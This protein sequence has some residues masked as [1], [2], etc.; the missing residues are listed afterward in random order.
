MQQNF[1]DVIFLS[2]SA[3]DTE[4]LNRLEPMSPFSDDIVDFLHELSQTLSKD[5][6][7]RNF[8]DVAT[9]AFFCRKGNIQ[10]I[11]KQYSSENILR[12]GR[13]V[14]FHIAPSNVPVNFAY[15]LVC[16]ILAG[17]I[18]IVR[19]PSKE[20]EQV[21]IISNAIT[22]L[23][24]SGKHKIITDRI[25]LIRYDRKSAATSLLSAIC[26]VRIIWGGDETIHEIRK[27]S[28]APRSFDI[29]FADRYS[30]CVI[31][32]DAYIGDSK[33]ENIAL[34][35]YNDTYLF[36]QNA[37]TAPH[38]VIWL[39]SKTNVDKSKSIFWENLRSILLQKNY[40]IQPVIAVDK[41]TSFYRQAIEM[42]GVSKEF[43]SDNLLWRIELNDLSENIE[44]FRCSSGYFCEYHASSLNEISSIAN[45]KYQT[46]SYYGLEF[47]ELNNFIVNTKPGGID[48]I[49]PIGRTTDF[50]VIWDG[51]DLIRTLS[52]CCEIL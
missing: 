31:N 5:P 36:D 24:E 49:V 17:N 37:C 51:Y 9:F 33:P 13:G 21:S 50:S 35:F 26:A 41:L 20:F 14:V 4:A 38:L 34:G 46:L 52:R 44:N 1:S 7:I 11:K 43:S 40:V 47:H 19:V 39:G 12:L 42:P 2:G 6:Q 3:V 25:F 10:K 27:S 30:L 48:R 15:S 16:G 23:T 29:T 8:P 32:A 45:N 18:N 22:K 28:L